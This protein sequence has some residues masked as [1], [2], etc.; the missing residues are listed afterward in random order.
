MQLQVADIILSLFLLA[1]RELSPDEGRF[2][3]TTSSPLRMSSGNLILAG[4]RRQQ[5]EN[6]RDSLPPQETVL[7]PADG[8]ARAL[9]ER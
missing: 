3:W 9:P 2:R 6:V 5:W 8:L 4:V 7:R 1:R